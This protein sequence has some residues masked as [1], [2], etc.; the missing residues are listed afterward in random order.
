MR[1]YATYLG[2]SSTDMPHSLFVNSFDE[3]I[4]FGTTGSTD[5]PVSAD[6]YQTQ[7]AGGTSVNYENTSTLAF[8]NGSD[9]F[10]CRLSADGSQLQAST[11]VYWVPS[12]MCSVM[13]LATP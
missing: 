9:M 2:G 10:V 13:V 1:L 6:A 7:H 8:P 12:L 5:F 3:L 4:V 11:Y